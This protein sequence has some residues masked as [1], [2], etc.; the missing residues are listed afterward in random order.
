M[1]ERKSLILAVFIVRQTSLTPSQMS[2]IDE[3]RETVPFTA[4][5]F[6]KFRIVAWEVPVLQ[7]SNPTQR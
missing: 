2:T 4:T 7:S 6:T 3:P 1:S 5:R